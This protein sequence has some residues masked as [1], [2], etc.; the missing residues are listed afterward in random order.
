MFCKQFCKQ[1]T[2]LAPKGAG[3]LQ[4]LWPEKA[5]WSCIRASQPL[6]TPCTLLL[7]CLQTQLQF[8]SSG[9]RDSS[10]ESPPSIQRSA[11]SF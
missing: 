2:L 1:D 6:Q 10:M 4:M 3:A 9:K 5:L 8:S 11:K 7:C